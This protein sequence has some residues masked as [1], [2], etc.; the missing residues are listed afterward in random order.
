MLWWYCSHVVAVTNVTLKFLRK[1]NGVSFSHY[2]LWWTDDWGLTN[3]LLISLCSE[4]RIKCV[5]M[6][7]WEDMNVIPEFL[8]KGLNHA[9]LC[10]KCSWWSLMNWLLYMLIFSWMIYSMITLLETSIVNNII[11]KSLCTPTK[12]MQ[13]NQSFYGHETMFRGIRN[14]V[15]M[16]MCVR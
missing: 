15:S 6:H 14:H 10:I 1:K 12:R 3:E 2:D 7:V 16:Y 11:R 13:S 4:E 9:I 5:F 8:K